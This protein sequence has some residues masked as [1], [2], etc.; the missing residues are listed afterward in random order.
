MNSATVSVHMS[1][2]PNLPMA[3]VLLYDED[4]HIEPCPSIN[5]FVEDLEHTLGNS[6]KW[7][8]ELRDG[9]QIAIPLSLYHSPGSMSDFND[10]EGPK[11]QG[12]NTFKE[13][14]HIVS[15]ANECN[16]ALDNIS[17]VLGLDCELW[18]SDEVL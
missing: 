1:S 14:G 10:L 6:E 8:L 3:L 15:W 9:R 7:V 18:D 16:G 2:Q 4:G 17:V 13:E 12:N 11:G 5:N